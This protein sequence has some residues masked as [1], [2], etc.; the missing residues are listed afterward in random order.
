MKPKQS[1]GPDNIPPKLLKYS[2][3]SLKDPLQLI[4]NESFKQ[5][6][7]DQLKISKLTPLYK[8]G[9]I[10]PSNFRPINMLNSFSKII[11]KAALAQVTGYMDSQY[12]DP[13]Q[14]GFKS[15][16]SSL[17]PLLIVRHE[18]ETNMNKGHYTLLISCDLSKAFDC[19][20]SS[21]ILIK[22]LEKYGF[23]KKSRDF[24]KS[25]F[26]NRQ[27]YTEWNGFKS[28]VCN[29]HN[30]SIVQGSNTGPS[31]FNYYI[32][33]LAKQT[34]FRSINFAD[35]TILLLSSKNLK[36]LETQGNTEF[37]KVLKYFKSNKLIL[38]SEKTKFMIIKPPR[39]PYKNK[40]KI[41][42]NEM[43]IKE[44]SSIKYLGIILDNKFKFNLH[45]QYVVEKLTNTINM[46]ISTRQLL[47][48]KAKMLIYN[49][50]FRPFTD[51]C[52]I[53]FLDK[54]TG[55]QLQTLQRLQKKAI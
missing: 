24:Y 44:T 3:E 15:N 1:S 18:I 11:E 10:V 14:F 52:S 43:E 9:E 8:N 26:S 20:C 19:I 54:L 34:A 16:H 23:D 27:Q 48:Y 31:F 17:H 39:K 40:I 25:F 51:Y 47:N 4:I 37:G 7:P 45:F 28:P 35:D 6:F 46:L 42:Q 33:D 36:S 32:Q 21:E 22:K 30:I 13:T 50:K 12:P 38:N 29:L 55:K 53:V 41:S 2:A 5:K 49:S